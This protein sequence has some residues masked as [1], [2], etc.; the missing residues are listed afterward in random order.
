MTQNRISLRLTGEDI[1][2]AEDAITPWSS[3][4]PA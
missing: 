4:L 1:V 2:A 3:A